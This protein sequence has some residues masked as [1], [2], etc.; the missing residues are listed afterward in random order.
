M[1]NIFLKDSKVYLVN[2]NLD[3]ATQRIH[4]RPSVVVH[5]DLS[6]LD[7][8]QMSMSLIEVPKMSSTNP[9]NPMVDMSFYYKKNHIQFRMPMQFYSVSFV[10]SKLSMHD[11]GGVGIYLVDSNKYPRINPAVVLP[12]ESV[13][14]GLMFDPKK[15]LQY[16]N[17]LRKNVHSS[18]V[19]S[20]SHIP[21]VGI[22]MGEPSPMEFV[23]K[24][25]LGNA[26]R[27]AL[28]FANG[29]VPL[30]L[31]YVEE[32]KDL[33][34][35]S[36]E[37]MIIPD[38]DRYFMLDNIME[39]VK[40]SSPKYRSAYAEQPNDE[41]DVDDDESVEDKTMRTNLIFNQLVSDLDISIDS[42][43][44]KLMQE[45]TFVDSKLS[46]WEQTALL[47]DANASESWHPIMLSIYERCRDEGVLQEIEAIIN[48]LITGSY[49]DLI[50]KFD[51][52]LVEIA[53]A[54]Y[55]AMQ[56]HKLSAYTGD[57]V[58]DIIIEWF[59]DTSDFTDYWMLEAVSE[60]LFYRDNKNASRLLKYKDGY[61][62]YFAP[63]MSGFAIF[64]GLIMDNSTLFDDMETEEI[65]NE[66]NGYDF[67]H[68]SAGVVKS[69]LGQYISNISEYRE[70][71][72]EARENGVEL[73]YRALL[74]KAVTAL[75]TK[76]S[77]NGI[78]TDYWAEA[79][80]LAIPFI[81]ELVTTRTEEK[82][83]EEWHELKQSLMANLFADFVKEAE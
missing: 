5:A 61:K 32:G 17:A 37:K 65:I 26:L 24:T 80:S 64:I 76:N 29:N 21:W 30:N 48:M 4:Q 36:D 81:S 69:V 22:S 56:A 16:S 28:S 45:E 40:I 11:M 67:D 79:F 59:S 55:F 35:H 46:S 1:A 66:I 18:M 3:D 12:L 38:E 42:S 10:L 74:E 47:W 14:F 57:R 53:T 70:E 68:H 33:V 60:E 31:F 8:D 72:L 39:R 27:L 82:N 71:Y 44:S 58:N 62:G 9:K 34:Y 63:A 41:E 75:V 19:A 77:E 43:V 23:N 2:I 51:H 73:P 49:Y 15:E 25:V 54:L 13:E 83:S 6:G 50:G 20:L 7:I 52:Q 78:N